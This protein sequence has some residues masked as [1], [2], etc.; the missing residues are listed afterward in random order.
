MAK[1]TKSKEPVRKSAKTPRGEKEPRT[2][3][4]AAETEVKPKRG[5]KAAEEVKS[6]KKPQEEKVK[7][8]KKS[9]VEDEATSRVAVFNPLSNI[10]DELDDIEKSYSLTGTSMMP[11]EKR[12]TTGLLGLDLVLGGGIAPGWYTTFGPEQSCKSTLTMWMLAACVEADIPVKNIW[13]YEGSLTPEYTENM[14]RT[15]G[16]KYT[17]EQVFGVRNPK[18]GLWEIKPLVRPYSENVGEKFFDYLAK[19]E[20]TLPDKK[21]IGDSWYYIYED[22]K[23]NRKLLGSHFDEKYLRKTGMLRVPAADGNL[24]A[25]ILLDSYPAMLPEKQDVDDP[26]S[27]IAVQ[28]RM[29]ADQLKR[30]KGRLKSKR[31]AVLGV[32]Q[33][34]KVP[35]AMFGPTESEPC[36]EALKFFSDVRLKNTPRA[37]SGVPVNG[38]KGKGM[39]LEEDSVTTEGKDQYRYIHVKAIKNKLSVP[40]LE[41]WV[42]LWIQDGTGEA[43]GF[44]PAWDTFYYLKQTGQLDGDGKKMTLKLHKGPEFAKSL[45]WIGFKTLIVGSTKDKK[46]AC[47]ALGCSKPVNLRAWCI[48]QMESGVGL[49]LYMKNKSKSAAAKADSNDDE[50]DED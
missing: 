34:R 46:E 21:M 15:F 3:K 40:Y 31:I 43:R 13:D 26:N 45:T 42:R 23:P 9:S 47:A 11:G 17:S 5:K 7:R 1:S 27:S 18:T 30:V 37:L 35:M 20:R 32:N 4:K 25:I 22:T 44:D 41:T 39:I 6:R 10:D 29:F 8:G 16:L 38:F 2:S 12:Q 49:D 48:K 24:Q 14:F 36:G 19:L 33:L 28:A 50:D